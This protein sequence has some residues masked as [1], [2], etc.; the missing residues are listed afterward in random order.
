MLYPSYEKV[1]ITIIFKC[2]ALESDIL[3]YSTHNP[4]LSISIA[5]LCGGIGPFGGVSSL[6]L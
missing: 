3:I 5:I 1:V 2:F 4:G 6:G